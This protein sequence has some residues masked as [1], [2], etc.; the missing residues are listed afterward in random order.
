MLKKEIMIRSEFTVKRGQKGTRGSTPGDFMRGYICRD[1]ACEAA[2]EIVISRLEPKSARSKRIDALIAQSVSADAFERAMKKLNGKSGFAF[3][4]LSLSMPDSDL[5]TKAESFQKLFDQGKTII[6]TVISFGTEYLRKMK[7]IPESFNDDNTAAGSLAFN[8][9]QAKLRLAIQYAM[10]QASVSFENLDW[11]ASIQTD[12]RHVH[13]HLCM[14]DRGK[15]RIMEETGEQKGMIYKKTMTRIRFAID[16]FLR[17]HLGFEHAFP[18]SHYERQLQSSCKN[19][20]RSKTANR[21][22]VVSRIEFLLPDDQS[23]W[24]ARSR[25]P[26]MRQAN[27]LARNYALSKVA[28]PGGRLRQYLYHQDEI[29]ENL[30]ISEREKN[31]QRMMQKDLLLD[32]CISSLYDQIKSSRID[33]PDFQKESF[34]SFSYRAKSV[35]DHYSRHVSRQ[36]EMER[37]VEGYIQSGGCEASRVMLEYYQTELEYEKM[38]TDKYLRKLFYLPKD[39][40]GKLNEIEIAKEDLAGLETK[41]NEAYTAQKDARFVTDLKNRLGQA[42]ADLVQKRKSLIRSAG[43][44]GYTLDANDRIVRR[45]FPDPCQICDMD[46]HITGKTPESMMSESMILY[47]KMALRRLKAVR[48]AAEYLRGTGQA[49]FIEHLNIEEIMQMQKAAF[50]GKAEAVVQHVPVSGRCRTARFNEIINETLKRM[51]R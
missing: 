49:Q 15:G 3:D 2:D 17:R 21:K 31:R 25:N 29:I 22:D 35:S 41:L 33:K 12:T 8:T 5:K 6:K 46:N 30:A 10:K 47:Q 24:Q 37:A 45:Q 14:A 18:L 23:L 40:Y 19:Q 39:H 4:A 50:Q 34:D 28:G 16:S 9:D 26:Q 42:K 13:C 38:C 43:Y 1:D 51:M 32:G 44:Y 48:K 36:I 11:A 27:E 20:I 7:V